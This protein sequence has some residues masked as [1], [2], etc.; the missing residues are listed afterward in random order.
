MKTHLNLI[1]RRTKREQEVGR[2]LSVWWRILAS[3]G[4]I[5]LAWACVDWFV[6]N[7]KVMQ[8]RSLDE[9]YQPLSDLVEEQRTTA[10]LVAQLESR[11]HVTL[12]LGDGVNG[13]SLLGIISRSAG[14]T[15]GGVYLTQLDF[16]ST[17]G[18][19]GLLKLAG[20]G[21]DGIAVA[22]FAQK[23][24]ESGYFHEVKIEGTRK[25]SDAAPAMRA[26]DIECVF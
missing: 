17:T 14:E 13:V 23:L 21:T 26:F 24:R 10:E 20:G 12:S 16:S 25:L 4:S 3:A 5:C 18:N 8:L 6:L 11:E 2:A 15:G 7:S 22:N 9:Q 19:D 1:P